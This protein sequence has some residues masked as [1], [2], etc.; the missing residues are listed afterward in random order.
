[1]TNKEK[2][3]YI[4]DVL[5]FTS[6]PFICELEKTHAFLKRTPYTLYKY[7]PFDRYTFEMIAE[8]YSFL[9]PVQGLDDPFDCMNSSKIKD[10][11]DPKKGG[12]TGAGLNYI[13][14]LITKHGLPPQL[15][16]SE[17]FQL[18]K[19]SMNGNE[20]DYEF[21]SKQPLVQDPL[22][23]TQVDKFLEST[24]TFNENLPG[25][26]ENEAWESFAKNALFP[27]ER[28]GVCSLSETRDNKPMWS[29]Y[30]EGYRG[31]CIEYEI[32]RC[33][34]LIL[35]LCPVIYTK[36][37]NNSLIKKM[38]EYALSAMM[39]TVSDGRISGNIGAAMELFCTKDSD[40]SYQKEW[41]II[42][43]AR[44]RCTIMPIKAIYLGFKVSARN[45]GRMKRVAKEK[46]FSLFLMNPPDATKRISYKQ[47][48]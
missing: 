8:G 42:G 21:A 46:G 15:T 31:Y 12:L 6:P 26:L 14:G 16:K 41:R 28:V 34:E 35:N 13:V 2:K 29:L 38:L 19:S 22:S 24:R 23:Q 47:L 45:I 40:W 44:E 39:R 32:P 18:A 10:F 37:A 36:R 33:E 25:M 3:S 7:R 17:L 43:K 20:I 4:S 9:A 1:M 11:Y 5:A 48:V 30:G 27:G